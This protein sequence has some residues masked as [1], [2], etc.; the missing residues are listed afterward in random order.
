M[1][2]TLRRWGRRFTKEDGTPCRKHMAAFEIEGI[3]ESHGGEF[4]QPSL[5]DI[6]PEHEV[7]FVL[8]FYL[9]GYSLGKLYEPVY[10]SKKFLFQ[11]KLG[12]KRQEFLGQ[13][14]R[15]LSGVD[16]ASSVLYEMKECIL[17]GQPCTQYNNRKDK[18]TFWT[19][20]RI[21]L[22]RNAS[23]KTAYFV[24]VLRKL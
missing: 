7:S 15:F 11:Q 14:Y 3:V 16:T 4:L 6:S 9:N 20:L 1:V 13:N 8:S 2:R 22:V 19:F 10:R 21:S 23:G 24:G 18:S 5:P 17:K 12:Y